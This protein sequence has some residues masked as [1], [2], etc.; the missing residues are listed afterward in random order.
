MPPYVNVAC[1][2]TDIDRVPH[3]LGFLGDSKRLELLVRK[4]P[5]FLAC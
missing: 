3:L 5:G 2:A 1:R 4:V